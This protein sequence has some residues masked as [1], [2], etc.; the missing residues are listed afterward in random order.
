LPFTTI[1][2]RCLLPFGA[3]VLAG[4][5]AT[6]IYNQA[7]TGHWSRIPYLVYQRQYFRQGGF[8]FSSVYEPERVPVARVARYFSGWE[9]EPLRGAALASRLA[10]NF[11]S[12]LRSILLSGLG[13]VSY[14]DYA[15]IPLLCVLI[16]V[17]AF[18][19]VIKDPWLWFL[20]IAAGFVAAGSSLVWWG[21]QHYWAPVTA[22]VFAFYAIVLD[23]C[24]SE[25]AP[26]RRRRFSPPVLI[27]PAAA[28][29]VAALLLGAALHRREAPA[30]PIQ[31]ADGVVWTKSEI[32][33]RADLE[34]FLKKQNGA[35]LVFVAYDDRYPL[36]SEWV[37]NCANPFAERVIFAHD[38]GPAKNHEL[39]AASGERSVWMLRL[40]PERAVL[41]RDS[42]HVS[43]VQ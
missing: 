34:R 19:L 8:L 21:L 16:W 15:K 4:A 43:R 13:F 42:A 6:G 10:W 17:L 30:L 18:A 11:R 33:T 20:L 3:V 27:M 22:C 40:S 9:H 38:L 37:Y 25:I 23:H 32:S 29:L 1:V 5:I 36:P 26:S 41:R 12:R 39:I 7:V 2:R 14:G 31:T 28:L 35:H 24:G